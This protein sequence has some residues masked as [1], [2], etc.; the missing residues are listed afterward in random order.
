MKRGGAQHW[1]LGPSL[2]L[3]FGL[4]D[5]FTE[6]SGRKCIASLASTL[7]GISREDIDVVGNWSRQRSKAYDAMLGSA[8]AKLQ[9]TLTRSRMSL[10]VHY[11]ER[12]LGED[13]V[14]F[15]VERR[16]IDHAESKSIVDSILVESFGHVLNSEL[17]STSSGS[18]SSYYQAFAIPAAPDDV[19]PDRGA[20]NEPEA[21]YWISVSER[22]GYRRLHRRGGCWVRARSTLQ[23]SSL[24]DATY[25]SRCGHCW[26]VEGP[27]KH[28]TNLK[29]KAKDMSDA[30]VS[31]SSESSSSDS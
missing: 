24:A 17:Q 22:T 23:I 19:D 28:Q 16:G 12:D 15:L 3:S 7:S 18:S 9:G 10:A 2:L 25:N 20:I 14:R 5:A 8:V 11:H 27:S 6:H 31:T 29:L 1:I 30:G 4:A 13:L 21:D 26:K